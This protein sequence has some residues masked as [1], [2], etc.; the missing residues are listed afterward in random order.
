MA[1]WMELRCDW[2]SSAALVSGDDECWSNANAGP[3]E[4]SSN[5]AATVTETRRDLLEDAKRSGWTKHGADWACPG[6]SRRIAR[7]EISADANE[8]DETYGRHFATGH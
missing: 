8:A 6:C 7:G 3:F 5:S 2:R 1:I 4:M